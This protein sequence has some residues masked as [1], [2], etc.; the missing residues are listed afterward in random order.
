MTTLLFKL[1]AWWQGGGQLDA[2][3]N[4]QPQL[5]AS[6][7]QTGSFP[8]TGYDDPKPGNTSNYDSYLTRLAER[9][10]ATGVAGSLP[11]QATDPTAGSASAG[12]W[13]YNLDSGNY[14]FTLPALSLPGRA[15]MNLSLALSYNS[16]V[17]TLD[18]AT[19]SMVFNGDRGFPAPGWRLGFGSIQIKDPVNGVYTSG[20]TGKSSIIY[21]APDGTR[22]EMGLNPATGYFETYDSSYIRFDAT[23][24]VMH[25]PNGAKVKYGAY[26][27]DVNV[28]DYQA[29]PI[30]VKDRNGNFI[31]IVYKDLTTS[32]GAKKV[33]DHCIDTAGR[34]IDFNYQSNLLTSISQNRDGVTFYY[35]RLDYQPVTIKTRF[36]A[37]L[38]SDPANINGVSVYFPVKVTYPTGINYQ[39][40]YTS[41]GQI[42]AIQKW[43]PTISGQGGE[44]PIA[45]TAFTG[46]GAM[47]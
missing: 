24:Q 36:V 12:G 47:H 21:L 8:P 26:S 35:V 5:P 18:A 40:S 43:V 16:K 4:S 30:E 20:I 25:F 41:Y 29:L 39:F 13:S 28:R 17:W 38:V 34:R 3:R 7:Q 14:N 10:N 42:S 15:G 27:Y 46:L 19:N 11:M 31:T 33:I 32:A 37:P 9:G 45:Q 23:A 1:R 22:H 6:Y 2:M 44:R